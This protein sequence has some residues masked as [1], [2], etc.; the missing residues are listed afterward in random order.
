MVLFPRLLMFDAASRNFHRA[1]ASL[2][3]EAY[4]SEFAMMRNRAKRKM[5]WRS[6]FSGHSE[7]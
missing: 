4:F 2:V 5:A 6:D 7:S 3:R 1:N